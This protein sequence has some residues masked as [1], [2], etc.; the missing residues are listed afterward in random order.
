MVSGQIQNT[1]KC[2]IQAIKQVYRFQYIDLDG[3]LGGITIYMPLHFFQSFNK[4]PLRLNFYK[5]QCPQNWYSIRPWLNTQTYEPID[6]D[7]AVNYYL[8][9]RWQV[10]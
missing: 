1:L 5:T 8:C 10:T 9:H 4:L 2:K 3:A 7:A 6:L